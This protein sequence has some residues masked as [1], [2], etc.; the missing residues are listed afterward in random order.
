VDRP[1]RFLLAIV[2]VWGIAQLLLLSPDRL[3]AKS[4]DDACYFAGIANNVAHGFGFTFDRIAPTNGYQPLW[5][6][7]LIPIQRLPLSLE[8]RFFAGLILQWVLLSIA[9]LMLYATL[10]RLAPQTLLLASAALFGVLVFLPAI[11][12]METAVQILAMTAL[13]ALGYRKQV[14]ERPG[15]L[16]SCVF[17]ALLGLVLLA[18]L[19]DVFLG[20]VL[21]AV[22]FVRAVT[23]GTARGA[24][25][26]QLG[27][28]G[29]S[30]A[31][32]V[33]PY[34]AYNLARFGALVPISG[35][36]KSSFP[37][38]EIH[39]TLLSRFGVRGVMHILVA[40]AY[41][42]WCLVHPSRLYRGPFE[43]R[44]LLAAALVG[45]V[46]VL[47]HTAHTMLFMKWAS[48][49]WHFVWYAMAT[50]ITLVV[51]LQALQARWSSRTWTPL[52]LAA[53]FVLGGVAEVVRKEDANDTYNW[54]RSAY[55]AA[56]WARAYVPANAVMAMHDA[57]VFGYFSERR[58]IDLDGVVNTSSYQDTLRD[59]RWSEY[60]KRYR[61]Q[62][63]VKHDFGDTDYGDF[64]NFHD[65]DS[66]SY[67]VLGHRYD[68]WSDRIT[69]RR[70]NEVYRGR[71][72][73]DGGKPVVTAIWRW[74]GSEVPDTSSTRAE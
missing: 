59:G 28:I 31:V 60:L 44:Y 48:F 11:N 6:Y 68:V 29:I 45:S 56:L 15:A 22:L 32:V 49:R 61:V 9:A 3:A 26:A 67:R 35:Q 20:I 30:A 42:V 43:R 73:L 24:R 39:G 46:A 54:H 16:R 65:Y 74:N 37:R 50:S 41:V 63:V 21:G 64:V 25:L 2:V 18:R 27:L 58:V 55:D 72:Y 69:L 14:F 23:G 47:S 13:L 19:D 51:P 5:L 33:A 66:W 12:G 10:A 36:L 4:F 52:A 17:G 62:Y 71:E 8:A 53:L 70:A 34:L 7:L 40:A 57:G 38:V 1:T